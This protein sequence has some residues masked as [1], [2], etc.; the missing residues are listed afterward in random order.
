MIDQANF[1]NKDTGFISGFI[2]GKN[3]KYNL[4][5]HTTDGGV[6]WTAINFGQDGWVDDAVNIDNGEAWLSVAGS[7]IAY[8]TDYGFTWDK[9]NIP[10]IRQRFSSIFFN[11]NRQ[12]IIGSLWNYLAYTENNCETWKLLPTPLDQKA[13]DKTNKSSRPEF[14]SVAMIGDYFLVKQEDLVFYSKKDS[15]NWI[16]LKEYDDFY[17]DPINSA[18]FFKTSK[19]NYI[20]SDYNL[21]PIYTYENTVQGYDSKCKNGSLFIVGNNKMQQ[22][23]TSNQVLSALFTANQSSDIEPITIG[24]ISNGSIGVLNGKVYQQK[25][26]KGNW[27]F[28]FDFPIPVDQ[29]TLT[30]I[31]NNKILFNSNN[32]S[33]FYFNLSGKEVDRK[34]KSG[35]VENFYKAGIKELIFSEGSQGC[36][37][38]YADQLKYV[39]ENGNYVST[40]E[41][42]FGSKHSMALPD[43]DEEIEEI[44]VNDFANKMPQLFN[45]A[46]LASINDLGF[47][48]SEYQQCKKDI[49][50][51]KSSLVSAKR[52]KETKFYFNKNN[53]DFERLIS[54]VD[55][56]KSLGVQLLNQSLFNLSN[57]WSTTTF[58][59]KIQLVNNNNET[60]SIISR[61]YEP[62]AFYFPW[63]VSLNGYSIT[64][65]NIE[66]IKFLERVYPSFL[67][68]ND[69]ID[70]LYTLVKNLY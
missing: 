30:L 6:K 38:S 32:D 53:I 1:F 40:D 7:G 48:E 54:L 3:G 25:D 57:M 39:H 52:S 13:Y 9:F 47:T 60:L 61:Y 51:F 55:S 67:S 70:I 65:T 46:N 42:S 19:G 49:L 69:R 14:T 56:I 20:R 35:I 27:S 62:N 16:W 36:F 23:N 26:Y 58:W 37:H 34:S 45:A 15:I 43:N 17:T 50:D 22:L 10:E 2:H 28:L 8:T 11:T 29:G 31:D 41:E 18:L 44:P 4:I 64:T 5:Y 21:A 66:I 24:Y 33:L 63:T 12:G 68:E 59:K